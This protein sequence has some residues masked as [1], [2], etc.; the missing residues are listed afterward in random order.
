MSL[1]R[2]Y[3]YEFRTS[4]LFSISRVLI[5]MSL[6]RP[7]YF[8]FR[9]SLLLCWIALFTFKIILCEIKHAVHLTS[10]MMNCLLLFF[11]LNLELLTEK[12]F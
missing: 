6:E 11:R 7:F 8:E 9:A 10:V 4:L 12:Q 2:P 1:E 3:Y 5:I